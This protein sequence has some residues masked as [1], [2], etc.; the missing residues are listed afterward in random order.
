MNINQ[1]LIKL[2]A[3]EPQQQV[4]DKGELFNNFEKNKHGGSLANVVDNKLKQ[5]DPRAYRKQ[6]LE[7]L[8]TKVDLNKMANEEFQPE[9]GYGYYAKGIAKNLAALAYNS[10]MSKYHGTMSG[11]HK[12]RKAIESG[13]QQGFNQMNPALK[14]KETIEKARATQDNFKNTFKQ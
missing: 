12:A 10:A 4:T 7:N 11:M 6:L 5:K 14:A 9:K 13:A 3:T 8:K 1:L 2:A